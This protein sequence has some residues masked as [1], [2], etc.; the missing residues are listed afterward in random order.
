MPGPGSVGVLA[1]QAEERVD[2]RGGRRPSDGRQVVARVADLPYDDAPRPDVLGP[3]PGHEGRTQP[4]AH[5]FHDAVLVRTLG[6]DRRLGGTVAPEVVELLP[7]R[8]AGQRG[9]LRHRPQLVEAEDLLA[10][11]GRL[12]EDHHQLARAGRHRR[13]V[14][15]DL[16]GA[17]DPDVATTHPDRVHHVGVACRLRQEDGHARM[18]LVEAGQEPGGLHDGVPYPDGPQLAG[19]YPGHRFDRHTGVFRFEERP[20]GRVDERLS[21]VGEPRP[22]DVRSKSLAPSSRSRRA[23]A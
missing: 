19:E 3:R 10:R 7:R 16:L 14:P 13:E 17:H 5:Q 2:G 8:R 21:G 22:D 6:A 9:D 18:P 20:P 4:G 1:E 23:M 12:G 11:G 15:V